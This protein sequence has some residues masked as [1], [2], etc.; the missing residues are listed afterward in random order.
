MCNAYDFQRRAVE[1][2]LAS[3]KLLVA[4]PVGSGKTR[5]AV[6][7]LCAARSRSGAAGI[8]IIVPANL[9]GNFIDNFEKYGSG[10]PPRIVRKAEDI[11]F[12]GAN[13]VSFNFMR[14]KLEALLASGWDMMIVDEFHHGKNNGTVNYSALFEL[15]RA[16]KNFLALSGSPLHNEPR[17]FWNLLG[18]V[19]GRDMS[20]ELERFVEYEWDLRE[21]SAMSKLL[22]VFWNQRPLL[23]PVK[24][25]R[26]EDG[27]RSVAGPLVDIATEEEVARVSSRPR[28]AERIEAV[29][30][31]AD[32]WSRY[33]Y[34]LKKANP[35][36]IK[37]LEEGLLNDEELKRIVNALAAARQALLS[38][39]YAIEGKLPRTVTSK[40]Q[41]VIENISN[42]VE[43]TIIFTNFVEF[44]AKALHEALGSRGIASALYTG[45]TPKKEREEIL[46]GYRKGAIRVIIMSPVGGEG[47]DIPEAEVIHILDPHFNP[48]VTRQMYGRALRVNSSRRIVSVVHYIAEGPNGKKTLDHYIY[49]IARRKDEVN[50]RIRKAIAEK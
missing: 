33:L 49:K 25:I 24:G 30:L 5:T 3:G 31:D 44:G 15:R 13:V 47:L 41:R 2:F 9:A 22:Q 23:G 14:D 19:A 12:R 10:P 37:R 28:V 48:E 21:A 4:H 32:E 27:F 36:V 16:S 43:N 20:G 26:D 1:R 38:S 17:E 8:L 35:Y 46:D 40:V 18:L 11:D 50:A 29:A 7:A 34:C 45:A 6:E 42:S 39:D